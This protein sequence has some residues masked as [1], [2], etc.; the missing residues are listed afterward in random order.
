MST[1][2]NIGKQMPKDGEVLLWWSIIY[3]RA[4]CITNPLRGVAVGISADYRAKP[5]LICGTSLINIIHTLDKMTE[6]K[7]EN[8][9]ANLPNRCSAL[10]W[11]PVTHAQTWPSYSALY[12]FGRLSN[13]GIYTC[14]RQREFGTACRLDVSKN[15]TGRWAWPVVLV[16]STSGVLDTIMPMTHLPETRAG[17][18]RRNKICTSFQH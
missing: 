16:T 18:E 9:G 4:T 8:I 10:C 11:R 14:F 2:S 15:T 5:R 1:I 7:V 3:C 12:R 17:I 6:A 13:I